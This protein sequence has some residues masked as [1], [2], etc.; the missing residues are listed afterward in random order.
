M[1]HKQR[2]S[3]IAPGGGGAAGSGLADQADGAG[4]ALD[5]D[6]HL[7]AALRHLFG[8][9]EIVHGRKGDETRRLE[10]S[11]L[12]V[13]SEVTLELTDRLIQPHEHHAVLAALVP[14][15]F[16]RLQGSEQV[17]LIEQEQHPFW[18]CPKLWRRAQDRLRRPQFHTLLTCGRPKQTASSRFCSHTVQ[19]PAKP[20]P[21]RSHSMTSN[22]W[23]VRRAVWKA[24]KQP[25]R[26]MGLLTRK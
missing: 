20:K 8:R 12:A 5:L 17:D 14:S 13:A 9:L 10:P 7:A 6:R 3:L 24:W 11:R 16:E 1:W 19:R 22:P 2:A 26:G 25:I 21:L 4:G 15:G 23:M 18:A